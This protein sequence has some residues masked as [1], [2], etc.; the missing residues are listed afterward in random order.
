M[1]GGPTLEQQ[2]ETMIDE[3]RKQRGNPIDYVKL[4]ATTRR[5]PQTKK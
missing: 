4:S 5:T 2:V 3:P 1:G